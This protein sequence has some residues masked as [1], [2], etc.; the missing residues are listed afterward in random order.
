M[1]LDLYL[2]PHAK[3]NSKWIKYLSVKAK[4]LRRK[5]SDNLYNLEFGNGFLDITPKAQ[6][7]KEKIDKLNFIKLKPFLLQR[8]PSRE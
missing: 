5:H 8:T 1:K 6:V 2:M 3:I 4:T 7:T